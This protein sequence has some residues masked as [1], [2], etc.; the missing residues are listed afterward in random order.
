M[1]TDTEEVQPMQ[2]YENCRREK[3]P[4]QEALLHSADLVLKIASFGLPASD[5]QEKAEGVL[6]WP[7]CVFPYFS[8]SFFRVADKEK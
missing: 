7:V 5:L 3:Q 2:L 6:L 4:N 8:T 1:Y